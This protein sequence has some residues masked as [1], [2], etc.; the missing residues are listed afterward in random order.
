[1]DNV[2]VKICISFLII[3]TALRD[4]SLALVIAVAFII[5]LQT[6]N[7]LKLIA[8]DLSVAGEGETSWLPSTKEGFTTV[9]G[10]SC[11]IAG[12]PESACETAGTWTAEVAAVAA[13]PAACDIAD[14]DDQSDCEAAGEWTPE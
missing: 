11:S 14:R 2:L 12:R 9:G 8:T 5:S 13:V 1:M 4:P 6:A 10:G 3:F 7:K